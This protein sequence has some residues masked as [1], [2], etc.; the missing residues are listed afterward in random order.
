M[1]K[2]V[3]ILLTIKIPYGMK[4]IVTH[5]KC[6]ISTITSWMQP[7]PLSRFLLQ[8]PDTGVMGEDIVLQPPDTEILGEAILTLSCTA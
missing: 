6:K 3:R 8:G 5:F 2:T 4:Y 7:S 1:S